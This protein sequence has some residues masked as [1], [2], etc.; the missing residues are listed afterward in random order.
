V[1]PY[2]SIRTLLIAVTG[3][4]VVLLVTVF[5]VV[6]VEAFNRERQASRIYTV[7][8]TSR[9]MLATNGALRVEMGLFYLALEANRA[10]DP[11]MIRQVH[12]LH[13]RSVAALN[14][15]TARLNALPARQKTAA[16]IEFIAAV[17][18]YQEIFE[19]AARSF[20]VPLAQRPANL[21]AEC[22]LKLDRLSKALKRQSREL[23]ND[24][25]G[26]DP[27]IDR[28]ALIYNIGWRMRTDAGADRGLMQTFVLNNRRLTDKERL[29]LAVLTGRID[30]HWLDIQEMMQD[31][32]FPPA[33]HVAAGNVGRDYFGSYRTL[34]QTLLAHLAQ[35]ERLSI[36]GP[37]WIAMSNPSLET[38]MTIS[39]T[40]L[41]MAAAH[42]AQQAA[43]AKQHFLSAIG[44]MLLSI[45]L[46]CV[47]A[48]VV[49]F[50]VISP[51]RQI[52]RTM[53]AIAR[54]HYALK[55]PYEAR[56]DE[57][58]QFARALQTFRKD[59]VER[60][61]LKSA[62]ETAEA[63]NRIKSEFLANMSHEIRTPMNGILGMTSLLLDTPLDDEQRR[64]ADTVRESG[65]S[66]LAILNDILDVS[67]LE[68]GKLELE[69]IDFD[70]A[71]TV[72]SAAA[73]MMPKARE[74][75][76]DLAL[77]VAPGARGVY[78][79]DPTRLRQ[80]LL[81]LLSNGI[82]FTEKGGVALDVAVTMGGARRVGDVVPL[83]FEIRDTGIGMAEDV[84]GRLFQNFS[85]ADSSITRRFG[86]TGLGLAICKQLVE[87]M[88]GEIG[89]TSVPGE[90]S[91]FW[92]TIP[93]EKAAT[94]KA[95][96][97]PAAGAQA[98]PAAASLRI[99]LAEDNEI[100]RQYASFVLRKA[101][102]VVT[103]AEN[104]HKAVDWVRRADFDV[105]LMDIQMP[106]LDGLQATAQIRAMAAPKNAVPIFAMTAH[107]MT[108]ACEEYLAAGMDDYVSKPFQ[109]AQLLAKLARVAGTAPDRRLTSAPCET[110]L[111]DSR[112]LDEMG[113][114]LPLADIANFISLFLA[115]VD[116]HLTLIDA[117]LAAGDFDGIAGQA[118]MLV[119]TAG[120]LGAAR[121]STDARILERACAGHD[122]MALAPMVTRLRQSCAESCTVLRG[123]L[124]AKN[125]GASRAG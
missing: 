93:F 103:L 57:I 60:E 83:H 113:R 92:F 1:K 121:A 80:I 116:G 23:A 110:E 17:R 3:F 49:I 107:A 102:H 123:W 81:N 70:L 79:G 36:T 94:A 85:Q 101:G 125:A 68:A 82:K 62:K 58:G 47:T 26:T 105:V 32:A 112:N 52:T 25:S 115:S 91:T 63:S 88:G 45:A 124:D 4:L 20:Q 117:G 114:I 73:L 108:G 41:N 7:V 51:L 74:K 29:D 19:R 12:L 39:G 33:L 21:L 11:E 98:A 77:H 75:T 13:T 8:D 15:V 24:I 37:Q 50:R 119:S 76:V 61:R 5:A 35:G 66:L 97:H 86:G 72:E 109:P 27:F 59:A 56:T 87:R 69:T 9:A 30:V 71:G 96:P 16:N 46:A 65:E 90:G 111:F 78:R 48:L 67:K 89:V 6:A 118:H 43:E 40:A 99:L 22:K 38:V 120:N 106:E 18:G 54:G 84:C 64:F 14:A 55:I 53:A 95:V 34:R 10:A 2:L 31:P 42:A 122:A 104:G 44:L 28:M 100:N